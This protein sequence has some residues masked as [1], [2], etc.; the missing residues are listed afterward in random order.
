MYL[1]S[2]PELIV[3]PSRPLCQYWFFKMVLRTKCSFII[4]IFKITVVLMNKNSNFR[5]Q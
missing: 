1:S 3:S 2:A 5:D 4:A